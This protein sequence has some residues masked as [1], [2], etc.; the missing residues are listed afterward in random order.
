LSERAP[1]LTLAGAVLAH[2]DL[3]RLAGLLRQPE[4]DGSIGRMLGGAE[5]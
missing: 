5:S 2:H 1:P 4:A 3:D